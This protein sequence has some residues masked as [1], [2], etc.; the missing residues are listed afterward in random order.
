MQK[1]NPC[2]L[3]LS[4]PSFTLLPFLSLSAHTHMQLLSK[5][6]RYLIFLSE[7]FMIRNKLGTDRILETTGMTMVVR[8]IVLETLEFLG[9]FKNDMW[10]HFDY[11]VLLMQS[12]LI[13][14][15][16]WAN[17]YVQDWKFNGEKHLAVSLLCW[18]IW[19]SRDRDIN[20]R[21]IHEKIKL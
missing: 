1:F 18:N 6:K 4:S 12:I 10:L 20:E 11:F 16:Q 13:E 14:H 21:I 8:K 15:L 2:F 9:Y 19:N 3:M 17:I 7:I 5:K